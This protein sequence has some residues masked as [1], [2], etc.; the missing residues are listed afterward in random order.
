MAVSMVRRSAQD[1]ILAQ[2]GGKVRRRRADYATYSDEEL[3][4]QRRFI[5][6][7][8]EQYSKL[9]LLMSRISLDAAMRQIKNLVWANN[10]KEAIASE[11]N[12]RRMRRSYEGH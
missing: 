3:E 8:Y 12:T 1:Y 5:H 7:Y 6:D 9:Y 4:Q 11:R 2:M 10:E